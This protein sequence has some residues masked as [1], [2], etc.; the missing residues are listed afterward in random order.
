MLRPRRVWS[1]SCSLVLACG[2]GGSGD[3]A[4]S[5]GTASTTESTGDGDPTTGDGDGD[6]TT[7]DGD[8]TTGD[9]DGDPG[10]S[11]CDR[12]Y[13]PPVPGS[14]ALQ[15]EFSDEQTYEVR[16]RGIWAI[17]WHPSFDHEADTAWLFDRLDDVRCRAIEELGMQDP[18]N[19]GKGVLYNVYIHH[20]DQDPF[21]NGWANG[22]GTDSF[23]NPFLTLPDGAH[24]DPGNIDHEGFHVFQYSAN[25][26]GFAY[27]G[28]TQWY[29]ESSAQWYAAYRRPLEVD[30][31]I[32]A[33]AIDGNPHLA[34]WH[35]FGNEAPG[36]PT[37]WMFQVR[38]YGMHT[39]L[40]YLTEF[41]GVDR[42]V[43]TTGFYAN[44][45][46]SPQEYHGQQIG[47]DALRSIFADWAAHNT[48]DFDYLT[49]EQV[50]RARQEV[51]WAGDPNNSHPTV[52]EYVD[53]GTAGAFVRPPVDLT[54]RGWAYN[55]VQIGVSEAASY[56]F[57]IDGD[58]AGSQGA[59]SHFEARV[60][61]IGPGGATFSE[62]AM[63]D[64][65]T[66]AIDVDV[67]G[68]ASEVD[69]VV[70]SVPEFY[71]SYQS[72]GYAYAIERAP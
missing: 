64:A 22:Q 48:N 26:P 55:V 56:R 58:A 52:A 12:G 1:L 54:P 15:S 34:L 27:A 69:L 63:A 35:S 11:S 9:G 7:G 20:G 57:E 49:P 41:A 18:P 17:W 44:V 5:T 36:D 67:P 61:V 3:D 30:T 14:L 37:D 6:P 32:E 51:M 42:D 23:G 2:G 16:T 13:Q 60:V 53:A 21:P 45:Q 4:E 38:Q 29:V 62:V 8:P 28:D 70:A 10:G 40:F 46:A 72:Y 19:P 33:G 68:D 59:T 47:L 65:L 24:L 71:G 39:Y 66:G 25:S 31:F 43:I 50:A